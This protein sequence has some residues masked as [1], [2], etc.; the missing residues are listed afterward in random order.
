M[1][2]TEAADKYS[3]V[4]VYYTDSAN[5]G[6]ANTFGRIVGSAIGGFIFGYGS[7]VQDDFKDVNSA[8]DTILNSGAG[9]VSEFVDE[10]HEDSKL[11]GQAGAIFYGVQAAMLDTNIKHVFFY[12]NEESAADYSIT[13]ALKNGRENYDKQLASELTPDTDGRYLCN[14]FYNQAQLHV[15]IRSATMSGYLLWAIVVSY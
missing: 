5:S 15:D 7:N 10:E 8:I 11:A 14:D 3:C 13:Y 1:I 2:R 6:L 4:T 9:S 12:T